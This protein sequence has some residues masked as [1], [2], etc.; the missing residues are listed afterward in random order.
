MF[1]CG[2]NVAIRRSALEQVGGFPTGSLTEDFELSVELHERGW[3]SAYV[4]DVLACGLGPEDL[5][6]YVS[7]QHRWARGCIGALPKVLRSSLPI[8]RKAQYLL[9]ASYF[10]SGWTV[11]VYLS[12]PVIYIAT[13][14]QPLAGSTADS[15]LA[16]FAPY[17]VAL[18]GD[19]GQRRRWVV[20]IRRLLARHIDV[21]GSPPRDACAPSLRRSG[22]FVVTPKVGATGRQWRPAAPTLVAVAVLVIAA[23]WGLAP[24]P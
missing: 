5:A 15:F 6:S 1:C 7:Q 18:A 16:A 14:A 23:A 8:R 9:S 19:G 4:P 12:L 21:L 10:L 20:H 11:L 13:G 22:S 2:T 17:F 24:E 3:S